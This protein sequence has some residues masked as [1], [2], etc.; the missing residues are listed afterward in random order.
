M[1]H[2]FRTIMISDVHLSSADCQ[3]SRLAEFLHRVKCDKL[4]IVGDFFDLW[5]MKRK[6]LWGNNYNEVVRRILKMTEKG[7]QIVFIPGNHDE[8]I[9]EY[10][11]HVFGNISIELRSEFLTSSGKR[12]L[13]THGDEFDAIVVY[14]K[15][16]AKLGS[17]AYDWLLTLNRVINFFRRLRGREY[18]SFAAHVKRSIKN[19][20]VY[21]ERFQTAAVESA[22]AGGY[23]GVI[24]GHI[25]TPCIKEYNGS[26]Y[27]NIGDWVDSCTALV[28]T[29]EGELKIISD[30]DVLDASLDIH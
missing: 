14:N 7:T 20:G 27:C 19:A 23:D 21:I 8:S 3:A 5:Q 1:K 26:V 28:E 30:K 13:V 17:A 16:L 12:Y 10:A 24:C 15:W 22:K 11:G 29:Y 18:W 4:Y 9:R 25:H 2:S 6:W